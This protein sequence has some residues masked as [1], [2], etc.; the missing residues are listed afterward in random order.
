MLSAADV[1]LPSYPSVIAPIQGDWRESSGIQF[2]YQS[3]RVG[4]GRIVVDEQLKGTKKVNLEVSDLQF[5]Q[6]L[7]SAALHANAQGDINLVCGF[8]RSTFAA[9]R[10]A[11]T[12]LKDKRFDI[13]TPEGRREFTLRKIW[14]MFESIGHGRGVRKLLG[15]EDRP[16]AAPSIGFGTA[17]CVVLGRDG[18]PR[19]ETIFGEKIGVRLAA[20]RL[21]DKLAHRGFRAADHEQSDAF[22][23]SVLVDGYALRG[24]LKIRCKD[25]I[26]SKEALKSL[27]DDSLHEAVE[28]EMAPVLFQ[29]L[30]EK[31]PGG[32][33]VFCPTGGGSTYDPVRNFL[34]AAA[35]KLGLDARSISTAAALQTAALGYQEAALSV[36]DFEKNTLVADFGNSQTVYAWMV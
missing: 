22:F 17:E 33:A 10:S 35:R 32:D 24:D 14:P 29:Y 13:L 18:R 3:R 26:L 9:N 23:D 25:G 19:M 4:V 5:E 21:K 1:V 2:E 28:E 36:A 34:V 6:L 16:L 8:P 31:N 11:I 15:I 30:E 7:I 12:T 20:H 27:V